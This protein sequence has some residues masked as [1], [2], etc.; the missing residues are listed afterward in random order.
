MNLLPF[1]QITL[2]QKRYKGGFFFGTAITNDEIESL[3]FRFFRTVEGGFSPTRSGFRINHDDL[4]NFRKLVNQDDLPIDPFSIWEHQHRKLVAQYRDDEYGQGV[5]F[6]YYITTTKYTGWEKRGIR[7]VL[8]DFKKLKEL[9]RNCDW[10]KGI[11]GVVLNLQFNVISPKHENAKGIGSTSDQAF[12]INLLL[13]SF[14][15]DQVA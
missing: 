4:E 7:L 1:H 5:D 15:N 3:D 9:L 13:Q 10:L 12:E 2:S 6:R 8:S 14:L 11:K